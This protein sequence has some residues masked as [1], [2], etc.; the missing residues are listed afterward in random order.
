MSTRCRNMSVRLPQHVDALH[1]ALRVGLSKTRHM[2]LQNQTGL[3]EIDAYLAA[4]SVTRH[5]GSFFSARLRL[6]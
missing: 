3:E 4:S 6:R 1:Y 5:S 2:R